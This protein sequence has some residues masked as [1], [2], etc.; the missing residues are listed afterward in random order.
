[1]RYIKLLSDIWKHPANRK[2][3]FTTLSAS[4][5][6][7][8]SKRIS[9]GFTDIPYHGLKLRCYPDSHSASTA[10]YFSGL[11]DYREMQFMIDYLRPGDGFIDVGA[12]VG[13]YT[14]LARSVIGP[15]GFVHTF[16]PNE[17][18]AAKLVENLELND[19]TNCFVHNVAAANETGRSTFVLTA[20]D[21][22]A[23]I[24]PL[25]SSEEETM[26]IETVRLEEHLPDVPYA[27][28]KLDIEGYEPFALRGAKKWL[29]QGNPPVLQIEMGGYSKQ[30][31][32]ATHDFI[33]E[34]EQLGYFT[35]IYCPETKRLIETDRPW[36]IPVYNVLA[37]CRDRKSFVFNRIKENAD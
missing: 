27:M 18:T 32:I 15:F 11:P 5:R 4:I 8:C 13:L 2:S 14:L 6:W 24:D 37:I 36:E 10:I 26:Q 31:G 9:S 7:Q 28:V 12:N 30:Y 17:N 1:M 16:E 35:A 25:T 3:R 29:T 21:C 34:L 33:A 23:H 22:T 19:L 20:D